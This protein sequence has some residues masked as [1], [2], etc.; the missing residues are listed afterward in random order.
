MIDATFYRSERQHATLNFPTEKPTRV[1]QDALR[2][3]GVMCVEPYRRVSARLRNGN[4]MRRVSLLGKP[5]GA[6]LSRH[7]DTG[8]DPIAVP[9]EGVLI[10]RRLA[11]V[12][13]LQRGDKV[14]V[15]LLEGRRATRYV[16][17]AGVIESHIGLVVL[18]RLETLNALID[19]GPLVTGVHLAYDG[20]AEDRLFAA[21]KRTPQ[22]AAVTLQRLVLSRFRETLAE[23]INMM[24]SVY[25]SLSM[26]VALG[27]GY[28]S[29]RIQLSERARDLASLRV[30]GFHK[31][32]VARVLFTELA[33]LALLAQPLGWLIGY[34][35][36]WLTIQSFS[37]DLY[38]TPFVVE[39]ATFARATLVT[40]GSVLVSAIL[41]RRRIEALDLIA[42]LKTRE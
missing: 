12:L 27:I 10:N 25:I 39:R 11:A 8:L 33:L 29:A 5:E 36:A 6:Q 23:N 14:E 19:E 30:L 13:G 17:V 3:P 38:T 26:I 34:W 22:I 31:A 7:L 41:V 1:V 42:V 16:A 28:N 18:M 15:E 20:A 32:E 21:I 2:L 4:L 35:L 24:T 37:S 40:L 9:E